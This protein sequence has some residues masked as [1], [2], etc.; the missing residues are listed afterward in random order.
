M[1]EVIKWKSSGS[2][3]DDRRLAVP[4][5]W[6]KIDAGSSPT[7]AIREFCR[8]CMCQRSVPDAIKRRAG[9]VPT[10]EE[11]A[12]LLRQQDPEGIRAARAR[13]RFGRN[14]TE[15]DEDV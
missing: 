1:S 7:G 5:A 14:S 11:Y 12:E 13:E 8:S 6:A 4:G 15:E 2:Y 3:A 10:P 9:D